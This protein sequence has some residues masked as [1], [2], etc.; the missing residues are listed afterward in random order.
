[1]IGMYNAP[2]GVNF[3][4]IENILFRRIKYV[5]AHIDFPKKVL[6]MTC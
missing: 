5:I 4:N 1:M 3:R 2:K 6:I